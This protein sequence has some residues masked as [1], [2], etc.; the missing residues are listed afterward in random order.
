MTSDLRPGKVLDTWRLI[1]V[2]SFGPRVCGTENVPAVH[3]RVRH[4]IDWILD[5]VEP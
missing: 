1:G 5:S 4:Y 2:V 3:S